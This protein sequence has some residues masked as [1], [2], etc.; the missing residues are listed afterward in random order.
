MLGHYVQLLE[1]ALRD[2]L[3]LI[4]TLPLFMPGEEHRLLVDWNSTR[5][6]YDQTATVI[7]LFERQLDETPEAVAVMFAEE[8]VSYR[9]LN[10][11]AN[12]LGHYLQGLGVGPDVRVGLFMERS[13]GHVGGL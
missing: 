1:A 8:Q 9:E 13:V 6:D 2:P 11:R 5:A 10:R 3:Q 12:R 4:S 7:T